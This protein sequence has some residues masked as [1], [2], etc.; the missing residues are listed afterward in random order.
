M[1]SLT[2]YNG[3]CF[4]CWMY[5][6][7]AGLSLDEQR[8]RCLAVCLRLHGLYY[9][10]FMQ[11]EVA[12]SPACALLLSDGNDGFVLI[13]VCWMYETNV[14]LALNQQLVRLHCCMCLNLRVLV[15]SVWCSMTSWYSPGNAILM[16]APFCCPNA[17]QW[18]WRL[19][20][21]NPRL[22]NVCNG[23]HVGR[24]QTARAFVLLCM[25]AL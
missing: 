4:V 15:I 6:T 25:H 12:I 13:F 9:Q 8:V 2:Y 23:C 21:I 18:R 14:V 3:D 7:F 20:C 5:G 10:W 11:C 1:A 24:T 22:L 16:N 19:F 17:L